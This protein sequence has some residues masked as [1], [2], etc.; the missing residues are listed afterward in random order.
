MGAFWHWFIYDFT[1]AGNESGWV[2]GLW[3][4]FGGDVSILGAVVFGAY[5]VA[6][7]RNCHVRGCWRMHNG[8]VVPG[9]DHLVCRKH[10]PLPAPTHAD[11]L[12]DHLNAHLDA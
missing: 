2:Y 9:T 10:H 8:R 3:S 11:V 5:H 12:A 4:G 1:G 6:R 7:H